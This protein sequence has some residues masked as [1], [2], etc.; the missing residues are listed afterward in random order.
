MWVE[1]KVVGRWPVSR[2][3]LVFWKVKDFGSAPIDQDTLDCTRGIRGEFL[4]ILL[5]RR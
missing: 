4:I 3:A 1:E 2:D 5:N